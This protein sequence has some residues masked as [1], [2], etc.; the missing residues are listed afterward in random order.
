MLW[1][2]SVAPGGC[3]IELSGAPAVGLVLLSDGLG[4]YPLVPLLSA[5]I[6]ESF[7]MLEVSGVVG[8]GAALLVV[9]VGVVGTALVVS[10]GVGLVGARVVSVGVGLAGVIDVSLG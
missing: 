9:S 10:V 2:E 4:L 3:V 5:L 7:G 1:V 8:T 6:P